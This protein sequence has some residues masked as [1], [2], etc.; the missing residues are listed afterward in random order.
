[1]QVGQILALVGAALAVILGG[2]GSAIGVKISGQSAA[3]V[4]SE[5]PDLFGKL[6]V[7]ELLPGTQGIYG[8]LI[9]LIVLIKT[10]F[11]SGT[12]APVSLDQGLR[13]LIGALPIAVV[14]L[15]SAIMQ[16]KVAAS[17]INM[18]GR[19]PDTSGKGITMAVTVETYAVLALL[20]SFLMVQFA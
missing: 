7:I 11:I 9:G 2:V 15:V 10:N 6:L 18:V 20:A 16:G 19:Q 8:F 14:A 12:M 4:T 13:I 3:G 1:M 5:D 17:T